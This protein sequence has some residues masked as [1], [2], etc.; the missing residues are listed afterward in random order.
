[1]NLAFMT[2]NQR[3]YGIGTFRRRQRAIQA[4]DE[5]KNTGFPMNKIS[6]LTKYPTD[7]EQLGGVG[8]SEL[9]LTPGEGAAA[10]A[11]VGATIGG[12]LALVAGL[13]ALLVP[14]FGQALA[15]ESLLV[16]LVASGASAA[17]GG[18]VGALRGWFLPEEPAI[19]HNHQVSQGVFIVTVRG[20]QNE[21]RRAEPILTRWGIQEWRVYD[22]LN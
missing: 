8:R 7:G 4:L 12:S 17:A 5:L 22:A 14:G 13:G 21:I 15:V 2:S 19:F 6:I 18:L 11:V 1:M 3:K 16:T 10:G 20:T 9:S